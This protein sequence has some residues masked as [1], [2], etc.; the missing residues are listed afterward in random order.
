MKN[1]PSLTPKMKLKAH[2]YI[3]R[4]TLLAATL[5]FLTFDALSQSKVQQKIPEKTRILFLFDG[6]GSMLESWGKVKNQT[7]ISVAK[8]ILSQLIDSL[9]QNSKLEL[10][11]R[12]YGHRSPREVN[13]CKD[14]YL[15]V[16]FKTNNHDAIIAKLKE[17][18]PK[19]VTPITYSLEQAA[20]DFP[21]SPGYRNIVILITDGIESCGGDLC[22]TSRA[23]QKKGIFLRPYIIG[24][25]LQAEKTLECAGKFIDAD[26]PG[27]FHEVLNQAI[28]ASFAKTTASVELLDATNQPTETNVNVTF[29]N[30]L[31]NV[32]MYEFVHF[33]DKQG[34]TDTVQIDPVVDYDIIVNTIPPVVQRNIS[35]IIGKHNVISIAAPQGN[36]IVQQEGRKDNNLSSV[37][38]LKDKSGILN[39]QLSNETFRYLIGKYEVETLTLPRR[40]FQVDIEPNKTQTILLPSPGIVNFN[41]IA[42]GYGSLY[43]L[44]GD[45]A[46]E[47][48]CNVND[49]KP[50]FSLTLL[51]GRY[52]IV[53]RVKQSTGSKYTGF[54][55]F[56]LKSGETAAV[57]V[58]N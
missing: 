23:L 44:K 25:G 35:I 57:S 20:N 13:N 36:L 7:K 55:T 58:F 28:E 51:P 22:T 11:L 30:A 33:R 45:G 31:T 3:L 37:I 48:V 19:G 1:V 39:S 46:Q 14:T 53:F 42:T 21:T 17:I 47:W 15:E 34:K 8:S 6:S 52:K 43:E 56:T 16:P 10:A 32:S 38:R 41:T 26:T 24:I 27:K 54:K 2:A 29:A 5:L 9:K 12:V 49:R 4:S 50:Q 40:I 18:R